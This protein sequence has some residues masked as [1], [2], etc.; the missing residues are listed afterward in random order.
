MVSADL[1]VPSSEAICNAFECLLMTVVLRLVWHG[2]GTLS[3][4]R[5]GR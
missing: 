5:H 2:C 3:G 1:Y 4:T